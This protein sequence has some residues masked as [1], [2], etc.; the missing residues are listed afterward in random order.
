MFSDI[1]MKSERLFL[2]STLNYDGYPEY[3]QAQ[4]CDVAKLRE[5]LSIGPEIYNKQ[6]NIVPWNAVA[7]LYERAAKE[8]KDPCLGLRYALHAK[9]DF[10]GIG[11]VIYM[12]AVSSDVRSMFKLIEAYQSIRTNGMIYKLEENTDTQEVLGVYGFSPYSAP[13]RQILENTAALSALTAQKLIPGFKVKY[14]SFTHSAP[15][16]RSLY[17]QI[18]DAPVFFDAKRNVLAANMDFYET[19]GP[20]LSAGFREFALK[21]FFNGQVQR[22]PEAGQSLGNFINKILPEIIGTNKS[23]IETFSLSLGMHS[24]KMQRLLKEEGLSFS[25][26]LDDVRQELSKSLLLDTD[27][28][29]SHIA[30]LLEY[31]SDR[32][33]TTAFKRWNNL[34][35]TQFRKK[36]MAKENVSLPFL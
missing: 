31:S 6:V 30:K 22:S 29:V 13:Y 34:S 19:Q 21:A 9:P 27:L 28:S 32:P 7:T 10:S 16:D 2:R 4:G 5:E 3:L 33:F 12:G 14:V 1:F 11:P 23:D 18:F 20:Q 24:K 35:P 15:Q 25:Q 26:I 17:T 8:L 36:N